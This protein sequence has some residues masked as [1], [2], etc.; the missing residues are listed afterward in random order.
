MALGALLALAALV[1]FAGC[2]GGASAATGGSATT[3]VA[4]RTASNETPNEA[5]GNVRAFAKEWNAAIGSGDCAAFKRLV[6]EPKGVRC[7]TV[8]AQGK[9]VAEAAYGPDGVLDTEAETCDVVDDRGRLKADTCFQ[10]MPRT[11]GTSLGKAGTGFD[12]ADFDRAV[13]GT[14]DG[15][16]THDCDEFFTY[17]YTGSGTKAEVCAYV[18]GSEAGPVI[19][20]LEAQEAEEGVRPQPLGGNGFWRFYGLALK[21]DRYL[22]MPVLCAPAHYFRANPCASVEPTAAR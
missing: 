17:A 3:A 2:G 20:V 21:G 12:A 16:R 18:F 19:K 7:S 5:G 14:L 10:K 1:G 9:A 11:V 22:T 8:R 15:L 4:T 13:D 6:T